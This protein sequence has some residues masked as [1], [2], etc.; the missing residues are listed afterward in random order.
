LTVVSN[1]I[2]GYDSKHSLRLPTYMMGQMVSTT[3]D[4]PLQWHV[5][6]CHGSNYGTLSL[7]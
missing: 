3:T 2:I 5:S 6:C 7:G 4:C 1:Y